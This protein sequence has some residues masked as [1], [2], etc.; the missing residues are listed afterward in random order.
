VV[1]SRSRSIDVLRSAAIGAAL[2]IIVAAC[3]SSA[4]AGWTFAPQPSITPPPAASAGASAG[5][6]A[7]AG[8]SAPASGGA[9][10]PASAGASAPA[11]SAGGSAPAGGQTTV[12]VK[13]QNIAF[14]TQQ[15]QAPGGQPFVIEFDNQDAGI[16]HNIEIKDAAGASVFKGEI[17]NGPA[18]RTY[19]VPG[20]TKGTAYTFMCDVHPNMT[21]T[22]V[23]Q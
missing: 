8:A 17:F 9:S 20:L 21:G 23:V 13:A 1:R 12:R 22:V 6:S 7:S 15:I 4:N 10:A 14:D 18:Q 3:S 19:Q 16:P 11:A 5:P 2:A